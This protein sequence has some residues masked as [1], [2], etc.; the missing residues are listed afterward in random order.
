MAMA[1]IPTSVTIINSGLVGYCAVSLTEFTTTAL[2]SIAAGSAV[3]I[4]GAFFKASTDTA[5]TATSWT[6]VG[7]GV[8]Q[9]LGLSPSGTAGSQIITAAWYSTAVWSTEKQ[10][11]YTSTG[12]T[13]RLIA[14]AFHMGPGTGQH[15]KKILEPR[16]LSTVGTSYTGW[17]GVVE[18]ILTGSGNWVVPIGVYSIRVTCIGGGGGGAGGADGSLAVPTVGTNG[19][20]GTDSTFTSAL[21]GAYGGGGYINSSG[22]EGKGG[23]GQGD[24]GADGSPGTYGG[25]YGGAG[26]SGGGAGGRGG[27]NDGQGGAGHIGGGGGGGRGSVCGGG[28][29]GGTNISLVQSTLISVYPGRVM[30]YSVGTGGAGGAR[31]DGTPGDGGTGGS[32]IIMIEY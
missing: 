28:G 32:G 1:Q 5:P 16:Q 7:T 3:E 17:R 10:G 12:S 22:P 21:T 14:S 6:S 2:S 27:V 24:A 4:A 11:W 29:G 25:G 18:K 9:Y 23:L 26:G 8:T 15:E 31:S 20:N 19:G 30:A 13:I